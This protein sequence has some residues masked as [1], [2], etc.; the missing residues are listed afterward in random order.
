MIIG[1]WNSQ[2]YKFGDNI[3]HNLLQDH[4]IDI[5][6]LQESGDLS[7]LPRRG[8]VEN[9]GNGLFCG[10]WEC[11]HTIYNILY[12]SW[13]NNSR[14]SM[15][16][17]IK[18]G[19]VF[20]DPRIILP[21]IVGNEE[22]KIYPEEKTENDNDEEDNQRKGLRGAICVTIENV[23]IL[24]V[25]LPS[26][27][28]AFARKV[29]YHI[30]DN[31]GG[32]P[33]MFCFGDFNTTPTSWTSLRTKYMG[34]IHSNYPTHNGGHELDYAITN[35]NFGNIKAIVESYFSDHYAVI[36]DI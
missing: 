32:Y 36:F 6:C 22:I 28:P 29:F 21:P 34:I 30:L 27:R 19:I 2:G 31:V 10:I 26:G 35:M 12:Y 7:K 1:T 5:L 14:C 13:R 25:H 11:N 4:N 33:N 20:Q 8:Y 15:A 3:M 9:F 18:N 17:L 23:L 16:I 24:N